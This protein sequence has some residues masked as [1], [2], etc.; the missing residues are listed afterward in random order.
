MD[1]ELVA[2]ALNFHGQQLTKRW[3]SEHG[4]PAVRD[5][6]YEEFAKRAKD[7]GFQDRAKRIKLHQ[8]M[9]DKAPCLFKAEKNLKEART[10]AF[11]ANDEGNIDVQLQKYI[12]ISWFLYR[13]L[14]FGSTN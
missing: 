6:D 1:P 3:E 13:V 4:A 10:Y 11:E 5:L 2:R 14:S 7:L 8:F 12:F 9:V